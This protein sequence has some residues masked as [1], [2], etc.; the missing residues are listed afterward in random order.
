MVGGGEWCSPTSLIKCVQ[1]NGQWWSILC[2]L[3]ICY[4][5]AN[6]TPVHLPHFPR[7]VELWDCDDLIKVLQDWY[8][9]PA[10]YG[11]TDLEEDRPTESDERRS[12]DT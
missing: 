6:H 11:Q 1:Q 7:L 9:N 4:I 2:C 5:L 10:V 12:H 8:K 3:G